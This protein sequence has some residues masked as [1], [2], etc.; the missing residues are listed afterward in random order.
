[1]INF[2]DAT[3]DVANYAK[4]QSC[5]ICCG[6]GNVGGLFAIDRTL[7][8]V[9]TTSSHL[10]GQSVYWLTVQAADAGAPSLSSTA[11]LT[12][13]VATSTSAAPV[14]DQHQY[15]VEVRHKL[16]QF[17]IHFYTQL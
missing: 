10:D 8:I 7:G 13:T 12:V 15:S 17:V 14:F 1:M 4:P 2:V 16:S 6:S 3:S 5:D 9:S 11:V